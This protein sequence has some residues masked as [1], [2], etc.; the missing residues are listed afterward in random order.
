MKK[1]VT[2]NLSIMIL[3]LIIGIFV[4]VNA[5]NYGWND[6]DD[7][8]LANG[9]SMETDRV[10]MIADMSTKSYQIIGGII[11]AIGGLGILLSGYVLYK[12]L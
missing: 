2:I 7:A 12:H 1:K 6:A 8:V 10:Y 9:G 3:L 5:S 11:L 4:L